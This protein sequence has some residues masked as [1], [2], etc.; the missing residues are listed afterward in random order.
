MQAIIEANKQ[1]MKSNNQDSDDKMTNITED[2][3]SMLI[4]IT[5]HINT[6]KYL[7]TQKDSPNPP[8]PNNVVMAN[9][10]A[11][12]LDSGRSTQISGMCTLKHEISSPKFYELLIKIELK[13]DTNLDLNNF[14]NHIKMCLNVVTRLW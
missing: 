8:D 5:Y 6:F 2:F 7:P 11:P 1:E 9:R 3:K 12:P 4:S 14:Y 10:R 13:G